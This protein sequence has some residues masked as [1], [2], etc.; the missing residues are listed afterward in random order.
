MAV[1]AMVW[2]GREREGLQLG[3]HGERGGVRLGECLLTVHPNGESETEELRTPEPRGFGCTDAGAVADEEGPGPRGVAVLRAGLGKR[4][5]EWGEAAA[6]DRA[7][8]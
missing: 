6:A 1:A 5:A 4:L 7:V 2:L 8:P 3:R